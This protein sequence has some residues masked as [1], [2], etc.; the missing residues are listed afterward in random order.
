MA[1]LDVRIHESSVI[2]GL[3]SLVDEYIE[4]CFFIHWSAL[5]YSYIKGTHL[6]KG[7][8]YPKLWGLIYK[9]FHLFI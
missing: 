8:I 9:Y 1:M 6:L 3:S 7:D 2:W 4:W 5:E